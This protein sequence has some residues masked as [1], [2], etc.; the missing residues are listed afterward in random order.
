MTT[1]ARPQTTP[2]WTGT[3]SA[4]AAGA[5]RA[6]RATGEQRAVLQLSISIAQVEIAAAP[7]SCACPPSHSSQHSL[8]AAC[9]LCLC[10]LHTQVSLLTTLPS[11]H[12]RC[13]KPE[14]EGQSPCIP[15]DWED[16]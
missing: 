6:P 13:V 2:A 8:D 9:Q 4:W 7:H 16:R 5:T 15:E 14:E 1:R 3:T 12:C 11:L 10:S